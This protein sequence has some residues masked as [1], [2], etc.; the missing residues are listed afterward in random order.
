MMLQSGASGLP[1]RLRA[2]PINVKL[3]RVVHFALDIGTRRGR[4][5]TTGNVRRVC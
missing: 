5:N 2:E 4:G 1:R 3:D